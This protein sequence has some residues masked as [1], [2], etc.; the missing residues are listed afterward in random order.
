ML[1]VDRRDLWRTVTDITVSAPAWTTRMA[2]DTTGQHS[3][4]FIITL[5][6]LPSR[7]AAADPSDHGLREGRAQM[8]RWCS[9]PPGVYPT[10][11]PR[12]RACPYRHAAS[13]GKVINSRRTCSVRRPRRLAYAA[14]SSR[15]NVAEPLSECDIRHNG[16]RGLTQLV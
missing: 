16:S 12:P 6:R 1:W 5:R 7:L 4:Q 3:S 9:R 13:R 15:R 14:A 8:P 11:L 10:P 2:H